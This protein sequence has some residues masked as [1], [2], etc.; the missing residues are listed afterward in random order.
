MTK[1]YSSPA[2]AIAD[3]QY[4]ASIIIG[5]VGVPQASASG[6]VHDGQML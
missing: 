5:G 3:I 2:D 6:R 1:V 4:G